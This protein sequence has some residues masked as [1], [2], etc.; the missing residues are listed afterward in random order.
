M[1]TFKE[2]VKGCIVFEGCTYYLK[3][4]SI[5]L[6]FVMVDSLQKMEQAK[7]EAEQI[8]S[9]FEGGKLEA[10][11]F[12]DAMYKKFEEIE[13]HNERFCKRMLGNEAY[14]EITEKANAFNFDDLQQLTNLI[15]GELVD[16][17]NEQNKTLVGDLVE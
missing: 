10:E 4:D 6:T 1:R 7:N 8:R 5:T 11:T 14:S 12:M 16:I 13:K 3:V 17:R 9:D 15:I 2:S